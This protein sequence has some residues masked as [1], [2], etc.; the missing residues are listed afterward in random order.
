MAPSQETPSRL[1]EPGT[2][3][4]PQGQHNLPRA[5]AQGMGPWGSAGEREARGLLSVCGHGLT[6]RD[7]VCWKWTEA[8]IG[9]RILV[10]A[11]I[12]NRVFLLDKPSSVLASYFARLLILLFYLFSTQLTDTI[13][14]T[15]GF[16]HFYTHMNHPGNWLTR[17]F[18]LRRSGAQ[19]EILHVS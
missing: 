5:Q 7:R 1:T 2:G 9:L 16:S 18:W 14:W 17:R 15:R 6:P 3:G 12:F 10:L 11:F 13:F 8:A 4:G 19:P